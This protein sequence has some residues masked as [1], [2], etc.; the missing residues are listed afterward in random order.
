MGRRPRKGAPDTFDVGGLAHTLARLRARDEAAVA[1]PVFDRSIEIARA[2]AR[3][4]AQ[5]VA[6][7]VVEGNY[8]LLNEAPWAGLRPAFDL[9]VMIETSAA[10]LRARLTRRWA[11]LGLAPEDIALKVEQND[12]PNGSRVVAQSRKP[13]F[14]LRT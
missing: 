9:S 10:E 11:D 3:L 13:D 7:V 6:L 1:V 5:S 4:I 2:G 12:L 8:L 14:R